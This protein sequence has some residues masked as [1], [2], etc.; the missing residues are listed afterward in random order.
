[1]VSAQIPLASDSIALPE[2]PVLTADP[3]DALSSEAPGRSWL[4]RTLDA[5]GLAPSPEKRAEKAYRDGEY[6]AALAG[7]G[8]ALLD[9]PE[10]AELHYNAA[11]AYYRKRNYEGAIAAYDKA[12]KG[13]DGS[14]RGKVQYNLGN[15]YFR[16]GEAALRSG[17]QEGLSDYREALAHYKKSLDIRPD[18]I[19]TKRNIEVVQARIKELLEKQEQEKDQQQEQQG[20]PPPPPSDHAKEIWARALQLTQQRRYAEAQVLLQGLFQEDETGETYRPHEKRL[21]DI[22]KILRGEKPSR[23]K[24]GDPR[25]QSGGVGVI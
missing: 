6:D 17:K 3:L 1:V 15:A 23:P 16:R 9:R 22:G 24:T 20:D 19:E 21:D 11:G 2:A 10:S 14:L 8:E 4:T 25:A 12:L 5:M 7:Y 18:H 13:S